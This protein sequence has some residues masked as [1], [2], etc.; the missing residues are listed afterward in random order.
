M[1]CRLVETSLHTGLVDTRQK[2][3]KKDCDED[4]S[5]LAHAKVNDRALLAILSSVLLLG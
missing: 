1:A 3:K 2:R 5:R 4:F